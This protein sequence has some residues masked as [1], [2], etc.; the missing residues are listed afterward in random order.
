M[1]VFICIAYIFPI[2]TYADTGDPPLCPYLLTLRSWFCGLTTYATNPDGTDI[3][4]DGHRVVEIKQVVNAHTDKA[5]G[6]KYVIDSQTKERREI[7][8]NEI[9]IVPFV[10]MIIANVLYD[11]FSVAGYLAVGFL[12]YGGYLFVLA[13]GESGNI[14]K[15][16]KTLKNAIIGLIIVLI[17]SS[18]VAMIASIISE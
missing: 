7:R 17:A 6:K 4:K 13:Q 18:I 1:S 16:R 2:P 10:W 8:P 3:M 14:E 9:D 11:L 15:G 5:T 12:I